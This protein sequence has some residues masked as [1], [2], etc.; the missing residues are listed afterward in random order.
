MEALFGWGLLLLFGG[1]IALLFKFA[2]PPGEAK[3]SCGVGDK[4]K[5][6]GGCH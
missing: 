6:G 3:P 4:G 2:G 1:F 5:A